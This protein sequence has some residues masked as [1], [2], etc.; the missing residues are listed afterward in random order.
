MWKRE[1][2]KKKEV[3]ILDDRNIK[4]EE[5]MEVDERKDDVRRKTEGE[6]EGGKD[7]EVGGGRL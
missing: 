5:V 2:V 6:V 3:K 7:Q 1:E 4:E